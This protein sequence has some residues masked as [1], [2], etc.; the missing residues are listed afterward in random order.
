[1]K[2]KIVLSAALFL[3]MLWM[4]SI[5]NTLE[6]IV[7]AKVYQIT[8]SDSCY[9]IQQGGDCWEELFTLMYY[10]DL[11]FQCSQDP[12]CSDIEYLLILDWIYDAEQAL[13][14]CIDPI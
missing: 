10:H 5:S 11:A 13:F 4:P 12:G 1:M 6:N 7:E 8:L 14:N 9:V 3:C 2:M